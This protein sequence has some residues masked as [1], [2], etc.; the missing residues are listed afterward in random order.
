MH[1][2]AHISLHFDKNE[3]WFLDNLDQISDDPREDE[4]NALAK[5]V[6]IPQDIFDKYP[7]TTQGVIDMSKHLNISPCIIAGRIRFERRD[8]SLFGKNFRDKT[9]NVLKV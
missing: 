6:L 2:L 7:H 5:T 8:Y 1:E 3:E 4:A 9:S